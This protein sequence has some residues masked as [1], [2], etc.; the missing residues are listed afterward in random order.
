MEFINDVLSFLICNEFWNIRTSDREQR[1]FFKITFLR[2]TKGIYYIPKPTFFPTPKRVV[3][4]A[5]YRANETKS[6]SPKSCSF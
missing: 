4:T 1:I 2:A 6:I 3:G 5:A